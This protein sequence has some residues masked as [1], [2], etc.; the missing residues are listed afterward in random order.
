MTTSLKRD[1]QLRILTAVINVTT[2]IRVVNRPIE[3]V[4]IQAI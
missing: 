3:T 4:V 2:I 1:N